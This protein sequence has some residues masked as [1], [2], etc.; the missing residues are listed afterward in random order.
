MLQRSTFKRFLYQ[1]AYLLVIAA[2][3]VT[4]SFIVDNYW[5]ADAS[6]QNVQ[7]KFTEYVQGQEKDFQHV[8]GDTAQLSKIISRNY[9]EHFLRQFIEKQYFFF[10]FKSDSSGSDDLVFWNTQKVQPFPSLLYESGNQGFI[11]L[12]NGFY[13]WSKIVAGNYKLI[14]LIPIKWKYYISTDYLS[15]DLSIYP[16]LSNSYNISSNA[17]QGVQVNSISGKPLFNL[18][19]VAGQNNFQNNSLSVLLRILATLFFLFY[20]HLCAKFLVSRNFWLG[21]GFFVIMV[22]GFRLL[23]YAYPIPINFRQFSLFDPAIYG[24]GLVLRSL[25]DLLINASLFVWL[26]LFI[27]FNFPEKEFEFSS[28]RKIGKWVLLA[29]VSAL[30][31]LITY[32][33]SHIIRSLVEDSQISFEVLNFFSLNIYSIIG[34]L[35]L[36][37]ICIAYY[38]LTQMLVVFVR[39]CFPQ[40][41]VPLYLC[42]V[43]MG[44]TVM[45]IMVIWFSSKFEF[46]V[47]LWLLLF[48]FLLN[49]RHFALF[50]K[51]VVTSKLVFWLFFFS[52]SLSLLIVEEN[53]TKEL[54]NRMHYAEIL[55]TKADPSNE[56]LLN[57]MLTDFQNDFLVRNFY[58]FLN[59]E[60]NHRFKD[61]II[62]SNFSGYT[63]KYDTRI[64]SYNANEQ[65]LFNTNSAEYND[66]NTILKTQT[67]PT[68]VPGLYYYDESFDHFSYISKKTLVSDSGRLLGYVF[69]LATPK[70]F[71]SETFSPELFSR[72]QDNSIENSTAYAFAIYNNGKLTISH[73]D[74]PFATKI[75]RTDFPWRQPF[76]TR[77]GV[78]HNEL[79]YR[80]GPD[81]IVVIA[82]K[83]SLV[84]ES[85]TLFSYLFGSFLLLSAILWLF[86]VLVRSRLNP[87]KLRDFWHLSIRN[88]IHGTVIFISVLSFFVIGGT[89]IYFFINRYEGN[90]REKL[91]RTIHIMANEVMKSVSDAKEDI[92]TSGNANLRNVNNLDEIVN[93]ISEIHGIDVNLYDLDGNLSVSS[94]PLPYIKG[95]L[96]TK[97][98]P[99]AFYHMNHNREVQYFQKERIGSISYISDYIPGIDAAG[100]YYAYLNIPY[101]TSEANL[102]NEISNFVVTI[103]NLNAFIFLLAG[104]VAL[105]I[106]NR[107][108]SSFEVISDKMKR[109]NLEKRNEYI[110]WNRDDELGALIEEYNKMVAK[111]DESVM[112]LA[113]TEREGAWREMA[114][115]VAH[116]IKNP[117]TPM[118]LSLQF[119]QKSIENNHPNIK[120]LTANVANTLIEQIDHL[121]QIAGEFSQFANIENTR[122]EFF[123][124]NEA[125]RMVVHLYESNDRLNITDHLR[126]QRV[127]IEA[128]RTQVN[129]L[130]TNLILNALQATPAERV[131]KIFIDEILEGDMVVITVSDNGNGIPEEIRDKIFIP[132][133]TTKTSGTG[134]GLA[135]CKRIV[136]HAKG[137]I[138]F[139]S[140]EQGTRFFIKLPIAVII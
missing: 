9:D 46:F 134:L 60:A 1:N 55:S 70:K 36:C 104:I 33:G 51:K 19:Q 65:P 73:N 121:N 58:R 85:V 57:S 66:L 50:A 106:A 115:Q 32:A 81:K 67:K 84:L 39:S 27:R 116:E 139:E 26:V 89:T 136:E 87:R 62:S 100:N 13:V 76:Y 35:V 98:D 131:A 34:F 99:M 16:A 71:K 118:K 94:L 2:W 41:Q 63:N 127:I 108:T 5:S 92:D 29:V 74:Y 96:S 83:N 44:F 86:N 107:I 140:G 103:I 124:L 18:Y 59:E 101:F 11:Q 132:N 137:E 24:S 30:L 129:R 48:L 97:M 114:R 120:E 138:W 78:S 95:V 54:R 109:I 17:L 47:L 128:D 53:T 102:K 82:R 14:A 79:W 12:E 7:K 10:A 126:Q 56:S 80:A 122:K 25:G 64:F 42:V 88:Q 68:G 133:F 117:L 20:I 111:L 130:F 91:S 93:K 40:N 45:S 113:K 105:F 72:G 119:L 38:L 21:L 125:I 37:C 112:A 52:V 61:S 43:V 22:G 15:N 28:N 3:L 4:F 110:T 23:S 49:L 77:K 69:I 8:A 6:I 31:L 135:M 75:K 90:N 123:D